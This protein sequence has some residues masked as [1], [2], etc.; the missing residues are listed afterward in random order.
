MANLLWKSNLMAKLLWKSNLM[1]SSSRASLAPHSSAG[2]A[3]ISPFGYLLPHPNV[4]A[5]SGLPLVA[6][7]LSKSNLVAT[8]LAIVP[9][10]TILLNRPRKPLQSVPGVIRLLLVAMAFP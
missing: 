2:F 9:E 5:P 7:L 10:V 1:C 4:G 6:N 3:G 8:V